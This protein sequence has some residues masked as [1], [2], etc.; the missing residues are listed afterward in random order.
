MVL[1]ALTGHLPPNFAP[2]LR[3]DHCLGQKQNSERCDSQVGGFHRSLESSF[4]DGLQLNRMPVCHVPLASSLAC[5][6][7]RQLTMMFQN[8]LVMSH[9]RSF[10]T[11][12]QETQPAT[13]DRRTV[14]STAWSTPAS[15]SLSS[16]SYLW[17]AN[18]NTVTEALV[19]DTVMECKTHGGDSQT[20]FGD[21]TAFC[22][23]C[24]KQFCNKFFLKIHK[25]NQYRDVH[26]QLAYSELC[27]PR[28][29]ASSTSVSYG[30][31]MV[32][33]EAVAESNNRG[34]LF[35]PLLPRFRTG[36]CEAQKNG[37]DH[38]YGNSMIASAEKTHSAVDVCSRGMLENRQVICSGFTST[39]ESGDAHTDCLQTAQR[40]RLG[41]VSWY[42][43]AQMS[44]PT[45][46]TL[47]T[48]QYPDY[49]ACEKS[50]ELVRE[51]SSTAVTP[52]ESLSASVSV[53]NPSLLC[54]STTQHG[55]S[56]RPRNDAKRLC[57]IC[58][59]L[60][61]NKYFL[62]IHMLRMHGVTVEK[63]GLACGFAEASRETDQR[64]LKSA[65]CHQRIEEK[66]SNAN[67]TSIASASAINSTKNSSTFKEVACLRR[68]LRNLRGIKREANRNV[69]GSVSTKNNQTGTGIGIDQR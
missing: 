41:G 36:V 1:I 63:S 2:L 20:S 22:E 7:C 42:D 14:G 30:K 18:Q 66:A 37:S 38:C 67:S 29:N 17:S 61:C 68:Y 33:Q 45:M 12:Y 5:S 46:S 28:P 65:S 40:P 51:P 19:D 48:H 13:D 25:T 31:S 15:L 11:G 8:H 44:C 49:V 4:D 64:C 24:N 3:E 43:R 52:E 26:D 50:E 6:T 56:D 58:R 35:P 34:T 10:V 54:N 60:L 27:H 39:A 16:S 47:I 69:A 55:S 57:E 21:R 53:T 32:L 23:T 9:S 62:R 59:K